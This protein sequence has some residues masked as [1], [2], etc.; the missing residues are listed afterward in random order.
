M[1]YQ[2]KEWEKKLDDFQ[3][4]VQKNMEEMKNCKA[5][6]EEMR[7]VFDLDEM[8]KC[9][10][11]MQKMRT[12]MAEFIKA[13]RYIHDNQ[14]LIL[15]APEIIIGNVDPFGVLKDKSESK[16]VIRGT[17]V[18]TQAVGEKGQ[19][20]V[21]ASRIREVAEDPGIDGCE[22]VKGRTSDIISQA[23]NIVI[24]TNENY[25]FSEHF[26]NSD[27]IGINILSDSS[28]RVGALQKHERIGSESL[29]VKQR[30]LILETSRCKDEFK[31]VID[32][33]KPFVEMKEQLLK[34][35]YD[36]RVYYQ[37]L[38][39]I[40]EHMNLLMKDL[41]EKAYSY[42]MSLSE[43]A[44][45]NR[46]QNMLDYI[47]AVS[48]EEEED[49]KKYSTGTSVNIASEKITLASVDG[50]DNL[51]DNPGAGI[52]LKANQILMEACENDG[53]LKEKGS[54]SIKAKDIDM[55][56]AGRNDIEYEDNGS[57]KA[58]TNMAEG[59]VRIQSKNILLEG[60]DY[61]LA[62]NKYKVKQL[63]PD[64]NIK[65]RS[66]NIEVSTMN[67]GNMEID[68]EGNIS[69]ANYTADGD[70]VVLSKRLTVSSNDYDLE[71]GEVK[72]RELTKDSQIYVCAEKTEF[73]STMA[74]GTATGSFVVNAKDVAIKSMD[75]KADDRSD[76]AIAYDGTLSLAA[77]K[78]NLFTTESL[79]LQG[80]KI[81]LF[82]EE[83]VEAQQ[84]NGESA[85]QLSNGDV[86]MG[87]SKNQ[88][89]GDTEI[90]GELKVP[91][92]TIDNLEVK[93]SLKTPNIT[94]GMSVPGPSAGGIST[95][96]EKDLI[97]DS[98]GK[99]QKKGKDDNFLDDFLW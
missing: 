49:F 39:R 84:G 79:Q 55:I 78:M 35:E 60:V 99:T 15:S 94:D 26:F 53:K 89:V 43:L 9:K 17:Q 96:L 51:R 56:T 81:G 46:L 4:L 40:N 48:H 6:L 18:S 25:E 54:V 38:D 19:V 97:E 98:M 80:P 93:T 58:F 63:T 67:V 71:N 2:Y 73:S 7:T 41:A 57:L 11:D 21:R 16:I 5:D 68:D 24:E 29:C 76:D 1:E 82:A 42:Y 90:N 27:D 59:N 74:D 61:E 70:V 83:T 23:R 33:I 13:G 66:K 88:V 72:N 20:E 62:D 22:H 8:R 31:D 87:G 28:V 65:L 75:V 36:V 77:N 50:D 69:K 52:N 3:D 12:E 92:A 14:R 45:N 86:L 91:T 10:A 85:V 34:E 47:E 95:K 30:N 37:K 64:S 44:E 32:R